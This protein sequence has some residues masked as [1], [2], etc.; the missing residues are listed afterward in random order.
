MSLAEGDGDY[1][2]VNRLTGTFPGSPV[3]LEFL[4]QLAGGKIIELEIRS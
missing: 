4:F 1:L 2:V 3:E